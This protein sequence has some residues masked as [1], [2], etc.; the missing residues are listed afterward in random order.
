MSDTGALSRFD[1][2]FDVEGT[3]KAK[4]RNDMKVHLRGTHAVSVELATDEGG[5]HGGDGTAPYPLAYFAAALNA[6]VMTQ[7]RA[8]AKRLGIAVSEFHVNTRCH[9]RAE[10]RGS[11][12]YESAPIGFTMDIDLGDS[13]SEA[14]RR[15]L[16]AAAEKGCFVEASLKPGLVRHRLKVGDKWVEL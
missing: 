6:C 8:F 15:R 10:Q 14:D 2:I 12:P 11:A 3:N 16:V 4:F 5:V 1:V 13:A 7:L 9:W